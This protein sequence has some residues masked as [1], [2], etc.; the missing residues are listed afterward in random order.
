LVR[1]TSLL[2]TPAAKLTV[3]HFLLRVSETRDV[4][5]IRLTA[6]GHV[7]YLIVGS[8]CDGQLDFRIFAQVSSF[9][10]T[11]SYEYMVIWSQTIQPT[12]TYRIKKGQRWNCPCA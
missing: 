6:P 10:I 4:W 2:L 12:I 9:H 7:R 3:R 1:E 8:V 5:G 11:L